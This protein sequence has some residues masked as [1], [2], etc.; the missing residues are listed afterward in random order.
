MNNIVIQ[1]TGKIE[2]DSTSTHHV[3]LY[4]PATTTTTTTTNCTALN[5]GSLHNYQSESCVDSSVSNTV[6]VSTADLASS[7]GNLTAGMN[8][9]WD[10]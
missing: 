1:N 10:T 2:L 3:Y 5:F 8:I 4:N 9:Y 7:G 6:Y